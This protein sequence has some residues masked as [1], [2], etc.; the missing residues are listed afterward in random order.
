[1][2]RIKIHCVFICDCSTRR[3]GQ[4]EAR[5]STLSLIKTLRVIVIKKMTHNVWVFTH[6]LL[7]VLSQLSHSQIIMIYYIILLRQA[8]DWFKYWGIYLFPK[9]SYLSLNHSF[10]IPGKG[11]TSS[12]QIA[13]MLGRRHRRWP[14]INPAL[15]EC[16]LKTRIWIYRGGADGRQRTPG[17]QAP[18]WRPRWLV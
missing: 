13:W 4:N 16:L 9:C 7:L 18:W 6:F 10:I 2:L 12:Y 14:N 1:M 11:D 17:H 3:N 5:S 15:G 8:S